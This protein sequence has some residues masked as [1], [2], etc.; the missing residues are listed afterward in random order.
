MGCFLTTNEFEYSLPDDL[1]SSYADVVLHWLITNSM[2]N[3]FNFFVKKFFRM[4]FLIFIFI[5]ICGLALCDDSEGSRIIFP[6]C[7]I[8]PIGT[9]ICRN[10]TAVARCSN[11]T[12]LTVRFCLL[13]GFC[14]AIIYVTEWTDN[15]H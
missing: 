14:R 12:Y 5:C 1:G 8:V 6:M 15:C 13:V 3:F 10:A 2:Y 11:T 9:T 7:T 4:K